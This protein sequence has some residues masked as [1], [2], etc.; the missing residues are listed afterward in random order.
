MGKTSSAVLLWPV[1]I[2]FFVPVIFLYWQ[3]KEG[4]HAF[5]YEMFRGK[6]QVQCQSL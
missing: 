6:K 2:S 1:L 4:R 3:Q 5:Q